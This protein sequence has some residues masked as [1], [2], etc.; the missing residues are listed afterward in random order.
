M[1]T[2][3]LA[4]RNAGKVRE[5]AAMLADLPITVRSLAE[6]PTS[7]EVEE[8]ADCFAGNAL[9]KALAAAAATGLPAL[10]DDSGLVVEALDG[11]P[12][13]YSARY[14]GPGLDDAGRCGHL[15]AQLAARGVTASPAHFVCAM[16]LALP[17][18]ASHVRQA[19][20]MGRVTGPPRGERGFGYDP[21][22]EPADAETADGETPDGRGTA[23]ELSAADKQRLSHR[24]QALA[25]VV[26][27][28]RERPGLL[29]A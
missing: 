20:W 13:L 29:G 18:G 22:F 27:L 10:A 3:V 28:L 5:L 15:L 12:G 7:P 4:T 19:S 23:A 25:Q 1:P 8:D 2:L 24:G 6:F 26:E 14:G 16:A 17:D 21:I 11:A 9:K